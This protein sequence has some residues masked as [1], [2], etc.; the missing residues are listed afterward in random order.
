VNLRVLRNPRFWTACA[1]VTFTA[2]IILPRALRSQWP[3][4]LTVALGLAT[5]PL[6][7]ASWVA[8][9]QLSVRTAALVC[10]VGMLVI[11]AGAYQWA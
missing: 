6:L 3:A 4:W 5:C 8:A 9:G 10:G 2:L 1:L 11:A 7:A